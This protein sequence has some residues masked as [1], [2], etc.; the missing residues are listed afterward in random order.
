M[1]AIAYRAKNNQTQEVLFEGIVRSVQEY[2]Y[3]ALMK[4]FL[5][6]PFPTLPLEVEL[7]HF[8]VLGISLEIFE[9]SISYEDLIKFK[10]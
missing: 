9:F 5:V 6:I 2:I 8:A 4:P 3:P 1:N 10:I 7:Q